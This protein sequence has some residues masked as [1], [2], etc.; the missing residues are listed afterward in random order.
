MAAPHDGHGEAIERRRG[1]LNQNYL[2][3]FQR[4]AAGPQARR[5]AVSA[6]FSEHLREAEEAGELGSTLERLGPPRDAAKALLPD[7]I[8]ILPR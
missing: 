3:E 7:T 8:L 6:E 5:D 1:V 2:K 4:W